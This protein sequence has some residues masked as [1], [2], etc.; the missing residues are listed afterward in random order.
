MFS[1]K[2]KEEKSSGSTISLSCA[3]TSRRFLWSCSTG[4]T[5]SGMRFQVDGCRLM[6]THLQYFRKYIK[7]KT[8]KARL[9][10][11]YDGFHRCGSLFLGSLIDVSCG[12]CPSPN[13]LKVDGFK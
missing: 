1:S 2:I 6:K 3:Q 5:D 12:A 11:V 7:R 8:E 4:Y 9:R 13:N 10:W